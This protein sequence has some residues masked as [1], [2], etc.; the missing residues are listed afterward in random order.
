[1]AQRRNE[2]FKL[3]DSLDPQENKETVISIINYLF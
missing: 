3:P 2:K 1:M